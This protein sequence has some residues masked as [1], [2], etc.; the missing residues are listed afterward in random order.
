MVASRTVLTNILQPKTTKITRVE[1][2]GFQATFPVQVKI[3]EV[4][5][6]ILPIHSGSCG[7]IGR[8]ILDNPK[9]EFIA[10]NKHYIQ[11]ANM[12]FPTTA[13]AKR[14]IIGKLTFSSEHIPDTRNIICSIKRDDKVGFE[15]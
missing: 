6:E 4:T 12:R 5:T 13:N 14:K 3:G 7:I 9:N 1:T 10:T 15:A 11:I 2:F 8:D